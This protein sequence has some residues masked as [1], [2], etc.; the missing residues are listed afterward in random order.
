MKILYS[1]GVKVDAGWR[2]VSILAN[3]ESISQKMVRVI[4]VITIDGE[5]PHYGQ[6]RTGA[7]R[8]SFNGQFWARGEIG[9]TKRIS[10]CEVV[11]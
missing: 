7:K 1:I 10:A 8:Q 2:Q 9:K 11:E 3:A 6:S 4:D 5:T